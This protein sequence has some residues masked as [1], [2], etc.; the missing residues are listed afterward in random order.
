MKAWFL[1]IV[2][3]G[4]VAL[5]AAMFKASQ[6]LDVDPSVDRLLFIPGYGH[7]I[8][9]PTRPGTTCT[10][11]TGV[12][13]NSVGGFAKSALFFNFLGSAGSLIYVNTGTNLSTTWTNIV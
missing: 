3:G 9:I 12:P 2:I 10:A 11:T 13:T 7:L 1:T 4:L 8:G 5:F 6:R